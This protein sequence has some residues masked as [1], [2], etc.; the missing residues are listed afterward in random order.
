M[1]IN[2][3]L[4]LLVAGISFLNYYGIELYRR[5]SLKKSILDIPNER[6]SHRNPTPRGGGLII[7]LICLTAFLF[8]NLRS[9]IINGWNYLLGATLVAAISWLD[10]IF[11]INIFWRFVVHSFAAIIFLFG[12]TTL[13]IPFYGKLEFVWIER[14]IWF[15]WIV[16]L[17]NAYNFMDGIDGIAGMQAL[18]AGIAWSVLLYLGG[19]ENLSVYPLLI[20]VS[21]NAFLLHNWQPAKIFMGDVG[22]AFLGYTFA[23]IPLL[24]QNQSFTVSKIGYEYQNWLLAGLIFAYFFVFDSVLTFF[25]RLLKGEKV[26]K[27]HRS[28]LYQRMVQKNW[29]HSTVTIIYGVFSTL[30]AAIFILNIIFRGKIINGLLT[31][32]FFFSI[33]LIFQGWS[34]NKQPV[35]N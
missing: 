19:A 1:R 22:S 13:F 8:L 14:V 32:I 29:R 28:H 3:S 2:L 33:Y 35:S 16:W 7:V 25:R 24:A 34:N 27:A 5:W 26:W 18:T 10:D 20:A 21:A 17:V 23:V 12:D 30:T 31:A 9:P 11:S 4:I 6:S 15:L